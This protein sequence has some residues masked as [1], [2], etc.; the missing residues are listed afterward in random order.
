MAY[1]RRDGKEVS[2][3]LY[4]TRI[5]VNE[6]DCIHYIVYQGGGGGG[7]GV[8]IIFLTL[9]ERKAQSSTRIEHQ[10]GGTC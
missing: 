8:T 2:K 4:F 7:G 9:R 1:T 3:R 5:K 10:G 6:N